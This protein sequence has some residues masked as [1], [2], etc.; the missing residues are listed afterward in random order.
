MPW[1]VILLLAIICG[2]SAMAESAEST[3]TFDIFPLS[4]LGEYM[5]MQHVIK[6]YPRA[7]SSPAMEED[8]YIIL[9]RIDERFQVYNKH[10]M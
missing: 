8:V 4:N 3:M 10:D 2:K 5:M 7:A 1:T 9:L 6:G